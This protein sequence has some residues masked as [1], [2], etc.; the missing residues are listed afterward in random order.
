MSHLHAHGVPLK[1]IQ[2]I[3][4]HSQLSITADIYTTVFSKRPDA[5]MD[6]LNEAFGAPKRVTGTATG[7]GQQKRAA[8]KSHSRSV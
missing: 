1:E 7:T 6:A 2:T 4:R 8:R 5:A 3:L